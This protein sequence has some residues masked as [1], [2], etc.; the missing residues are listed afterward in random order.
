[1]YKRKSTATLYKGYMIDH[2]DFY[3]NGER[4]YIW[5]D[6]I[7]GVINIDPRREGYDTKK[8]AKTAIDEY[9]KRS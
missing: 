1:M 2:G 8:E 7:K 4:W 9:R 6:L 5:D 3:G